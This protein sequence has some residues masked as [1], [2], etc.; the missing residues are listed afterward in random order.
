VDRQKDGRTDTILNITLSY[1][2][3]IAKKVQKL[4]V[5]FREDC[6]HSYSVK[7]TEWRVPLLHEVALVHATCPH[8]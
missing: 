7:K 5:L 4:S 1:Y 2:I 6:V 3:L 8:L